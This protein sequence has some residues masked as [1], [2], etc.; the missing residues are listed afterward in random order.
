MQA[1]LTPEERSLSAAALRRIDQWCDLFEQQSQSGLRPRIEQVLEEAA[2][3]EKSI[4]LRY[5]IRCE[6]EGRGRAATRPSLAEYQARFPQYG[7]VIAEEFASFPWGDVTGHAPAAAPPS[8][9]KPDQARQEQ[10]AFP[11]QLAGRYTLRGEIGRGGCARVL[12]AEDEQLHRQ[13]AIKV[14]L[15]DT[16]IDSGVYLAEAQAVAQLTHPG[17]VPV[18]DVGQDSQDR[19]FVVMQYAEGPSLAERLEQGPLPPSEAAQLLAQVADA[20]HHAHQQGFV[21]RDLKPSNILLSRD[22]RPLVSDFGLALHERD[23]ARHRGDYSGTPLYRAPEQ[24][25]GEADWMDGRCDIW[26]LGVVLYEMLTGRRP[27]ANSDEILLRPPKPPRQIN[28]RVP[29]PLEQICLKCLSKTIDDR[30]AAADV[31]ARELRD[32]YASL[33]AKG[34]LAGDDAGSSSGLSG[35]DKIIIVQNLVSAPTVPTTVETI[36]ANPYVGLFAFGEGDAGRF[37]GREELTERIIERFRALQDETRPD[38]ATTRLLPI[39]GPSGCGKS[40]LVRAGLVAQLAQH[41]I[42]GWRDIRAVI[43]QP[44]SRPLESMATA[45]ARLLTNEPTPLSKSVELQQVLRVQREGTGDRRCDGLRQIA[46]SLSTDHRSPLLVVVDQMD[47]LYSLCDDRQ[48]RDIFLDNLLV[49][50]SE[51]GGAVSVVFTLRSDFLGETHDHP[52]LNGLIAQ[53]A[54]LV[55]AMTKD[56]L[57]AAI[58][59]PARVAG[60]P[61]DT[62]LV[63][64]LAEQTYG[65]EGALPLLQFALTRIWQGLVEGTKPA[66]TLQQLGGV[67]GALSGEAQRIYD[68]LEPRDRQ[69]ARRVF[70]S[71]VQL[72]QTA[73]DTRRRVEVFSLVAHAEDPAR[74]RGVITRFATP[75]ARLLTLSAVGQ[76]GAETVEVTH[77]A[78]FEH[79]PQMRQWLDEGRS[80]LRFQR[81]LDEAARHWQDEGKPA[82]LLWRSPDLDRLRHYHQTS[83]PEMTPAQIE[84]FAGSCRLE[85]EDQTRQKRRFQLYRYAAIVFFLLATTAGGL[86]IL[87]QRNAADANQRRLR[88]NLDEGLRRMDDQDLMGAVPKLVEALGL[89]QGQPDDVKERHRLRLGAVLAQC[90]KPIQVFH[91]ER[92]IVYTELSPDGRLVSMAGREGGIKLW[93]V[94]TG[95]E[96]Q[97]IQNA[98]T[99]TVRIASFSPDGTKLLTAS[100]DGTA[101]VWDVKTGEPLTDKLPHD[102]R[103]RHAAFAPDGRMLV[104]AGE[105]GTAK[106]WSLDQG[107]LV[108][109]P[110]E[111]PDQTMPI[112][113]TVFSPDGTQLVT[114]SDDATAMVWNVDDGTKIAG[115]LEHD[116][117]VYSAAF[118]PDGTLLL[119][120]SDDAT[121]RLWSLPKGEPKGKLPH[122]HR[123]RFVTFGPRGQYFATASFDGTARLWNS[124]SMLAKATIRHSQE[125]NHAA[126]DVGGRWLATASSDGTV[127]VINT[128]TGHLIL[129]PLR[130]SAGVNR[131][132]FREQRR[133]LVTVAHDGIMRLWRIPQQSVRSGSQLP[134]G[135]AVLLASV[136][137]H[138]RRIA[139]L[140][141]DQTIR[142]WDV[143]TEKLAVWPM[144]QGFT[145]ARVIFSPQG[146]AVLACR[147]PF[148]FFWNVESGLP[149]TLFRLQDWQPERSLVFRPSGE[150]VAAIT[151]PPRRV[152]ICDTRKGESRNIPLPTN[153]S[154]LDVAFAADGKHLAVATGST[155]G[156]QGKVRIFQLPD[157]PL[158]EAVRE[159]PSVS[160]NDH[161]NFVTFCGREGTR[162]AAAT[163]TMYVSPM[164]IL[165]TAGKVYVWE[166]KSLERDPK[167]MLHPEIVTRVLFSPNGR[168]L[169]TISTDRV[170]RI[171]DTENGKQVTRP[172]AHEDAVREMAFSL[173]GKYLITAVGAEHPASHA[174]GYVRIWD[175]ASGEPITAKLMSTGP[176]FAAAF[177]DNNLRFVSA[178][179]QGVKIGK[180][181]SLY[182]PLD[183]W[184]KVG[185]VLSGQQTF[186]D[187]SSKPLA[188]KEYVKSWQ[189]LTEKYPDEF[190]PGRLPGPSADPDQLV[191]IDSQWKYSDTGEDLGQAWR[192]PDLD[193]SAWPSGAAQLGYGEADESTVLDATDAPVT[194][195]FRHSFEVA[196]APAVKDLVLTLT[197]DDG[198]HVYLNGTR[199]ATCNLP[200]DARHDESAIDPID[201][202]GEGL[203]LCAAVDSCLLVTGKNLLAVEIH[204]FSKPDHDPRGH[205]LSFQLSLTANASQVYAEVLDEPGLPWDRAQAANVLGILPKGDPQNRAALER[206]LQDDNALVKGWAAMSLA[207]LEEGEL[208]ESFQDL[209]PEEPYMRQLIA[210]H[211]NHPS[212][213]VAKVPGLTDAEYQGALRGAR[214]LTELIPDDPNRWNTLGVARYRVGQYPEVIHAL[215]ESDRLLT[216]GGRSRYPGNAFFMAMAK[217]QQGELLEARQRL[218]EG[219]DLM[220]ELPEMSSDYYST[221]RFRDEV[222]QLIGIEKVAPE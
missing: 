202:Y 177:L 128:D 131:V 44:G 28:D 119:T 78:I 174:P 207:R 55:P 21:H 185:K 79:W 113:Y 19:P 172:M 97:W 86:G 82:G 58:A 18:H 105:D 195:Y 194:T 182:R 150:Y 33:V 103:L 164:G 1:K 81:R 215:S 220:N 184:V 178:G 46:S 80:D 200:V 34:I 35:H 40:S 42:P 57:R 83:G 132:F 3:S 163:G 115:P 186:D 48:E 36:A 187:Q 204:Q 141:R 148:M 60:H 181:Q 121:A 14:P 7:D 160:L 112:N 102:A 32:A 206:A 219:L 59:E 205:D 171:W 26:S 24:V 72:G 66:E 53:Q 180:F 218:K 130:H 191:A 92:M 50:A 127:Q 143:N 196:N 100:R 197:Y 193:D 189:A 135:D 175:A 8:P 124:Q 108:G 49:A 129:P 56:Q 110:L 54:V 106:L 183:D 61:L 45:L 15:P 91:D 139:T 154:A 125:V 90:P 11:R 176:M 165:P 159:G 126:F 94:G 75:A 2:D 211:L 152:W 201:G 95:E 41:P 203:P 166:T 134:H 198:A 210:R 30:F 99:D 71:L 151:P 47:E 67:G 142:L 209:L 137:P 155:D 157:N 122:D 51:A 213:S 89:I 144:S 217:F 85:D 123:V 20:V 167:Q 38:K 133:E 104:T 107:T 145:P 118:S 63:D 22:G 153:E 138:R 216:E 31:L 96:R 12:L 117:G 23:Q 98:H 10:A 120:G 13:V 6:W 188:P 17:I 214:M 136:G 62:A 88:L 179:T 149:I 25:R 37:F 199:I 29:E 147:G 222:V 140:G 162:L 146:D 76:A 156:Q 212:W 173:D 190:S 4:L 93:D 52:W 9:N 192:L 168:R 27:F 64:L 101:R 208:A 158:T 74:V 87:A 73:P 161:V 68:G 70:L 5:L 39:V 169:A 109:Q 16:D 170:V 111:H 43:F 116:R 221:Q 69:L 65:R 77:E 114:M 84:F